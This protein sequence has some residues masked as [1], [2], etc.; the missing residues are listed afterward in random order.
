MLRPV[1]N[2][3]HSREALSR[4]A[5]LWTGADE[6]HWLDWLTIVERA[7]VPALQRLASEAPQESYTYAVVF[8]M[9]GSSMCPE[10]VGLVQQ[11]DKGG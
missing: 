4:D 1:G 3:R 11:M 5:T 2:R 8:G 10:A 9:G 6:E 7:D